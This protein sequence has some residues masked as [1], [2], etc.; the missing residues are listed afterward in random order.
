MHAYMSRFQEEIARLK[1][2]LGG[3]GGG[4]DGHSSQRV[5]ELAGQLAERDRELESMRA[6]LAIAPEWQESDAVGLRTGLLVARIGVGC[7]GLVDGATVA[8]GPLL[9]L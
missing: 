4:G 3:G 5:E 2:E 8:G 6:E 1:A 9:P 7:H